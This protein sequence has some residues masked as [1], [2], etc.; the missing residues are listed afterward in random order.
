MSGQGKLV[1]LAGDAGIGKTRI[2]QELAGHARAQGAQVLWGSCYEGGG[3]TGIAEIIPQMAQKLPD[4][5]KPPAL[6]PEQA[7]FQLF[8]SVATFLNRASIACPTLIVLEL[9]DRMLAVMAR[10]EPSP[11]QYM[12]IRRSH[13]P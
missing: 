2:A 1:M 6:E 5:A 13:Y 7:R 12:R 8:D 11:R 9:L 10:T 3:N 4:L